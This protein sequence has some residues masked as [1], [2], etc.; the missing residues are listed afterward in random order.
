MERDYRVAMQV[1]EALSADEWEQVTSDAFV[2]L[3]CAAFERDFRGRIEVERF[4]A[5]D[6][7]HLM[8]SHV[9]TDG[10]AV[11]RTPRQAAHANSDD[12]HL[13]FTLGGPG[14]I[15]Q[16]GHVAR[17][18][19]GSVSSYATDR[20]YQL[21][22]TAPGQRQ[23]LVQVSKRALGVPVDLVERSCEL[24]LIDAAEAAE[25]LSTTI[26]ESRGSADAAAGDPTTAETLRDLVATMLR[27][28][29][30]GTRALPATRGGMLATVRGFMRGHL[31]DAALDVGQI[32]E[33]HYVSRR[34]LY[35]LF[36][37]FAETP[38]EHLRRLRLTRARTLLTSDLTIAEIAGRCGFAD[39]TTFTRAFHREFGM[40]PSDARR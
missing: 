10:L 40:L 36:E 21:D 20:S 34:Y 15:R 25:A 38:G 16:D 3:T 6:A 23:I 35:E 33:A 29:V 4:D 14:V 17:V 1:V 24:I 26:A 32:A 9:T 28:S 19:A 5:G 11:D 7:G 12:I 18:G 37:P 22:Y 2:P 8:V 30:L 39:P 13:T 27:T 31:H